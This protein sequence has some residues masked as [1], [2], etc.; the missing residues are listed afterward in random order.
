VYPELLLQLGLQVGDKIE[1]GGRSFTIKDTVLEDSTQTFRMA[2]LA[3]KI[4]VSRSAIEKTQLLQF[5]T[6]LSDI[7]MLKL[8]HKKADEAAVAALSSMGDHVLK[9][10]KDPAIQWTTY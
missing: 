2:S 7:L 5:G 1:L 10:I 3:P 9:E 4:Y 8:N 6:T